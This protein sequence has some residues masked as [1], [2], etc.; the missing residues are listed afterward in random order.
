VSGVLGEKNG[1]EAG[2]GGQV[3]DGP[4]R[5]IS[6]NQTLLLLLDVTLSVRTTPYWPPYN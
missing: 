6:V 2:D 1:K 3:R 5:V 4:G